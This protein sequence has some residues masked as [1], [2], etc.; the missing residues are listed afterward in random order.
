MLNNCL[1][2]SFQ[3][4]YYMWKAYYISAIPHYLEN[5]FHL[6]CS[7]KKCF[8]R[9][10]FPHYTNAG[11]MFRRPNLPASKKPFIFA[12]ER[13]VSTC[14]AQR[15]VIWFLGDIFSEKPDHW[16]F[17]WVKIHN[18][19]YI[20]HCQVKCGRC[21]VVPLKGCNTLQLL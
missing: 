8:L 13:A 3:C 21:V 16:W 4:Y 14:A 11:I 18:I 17:M 15:F 10:Y 2:I 1:I 5:C 9:N 7:G 6:L 12:R 19:K 20:L